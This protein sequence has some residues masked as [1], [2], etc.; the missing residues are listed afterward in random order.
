MTALVQVPD[1]NL[2]AVLASQ[3]QLRVDAVFYHVRRAP[4]GGNH[5]VMSQVPPEVVCQ[6]L[7]AT[8][9]FPGTLQLKRVRVH[10][11]N[12]TGAVSASRSECAPVNAVRSTMKRVGRRVA[13]LLYE[14]FGLDHLHNLRLPGIRLRVQNVNP[15]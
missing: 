11:E 13:S 12:A 2:V 9:L 3:Q 8:I 14:L 6:L 10:Q 1:M 7:W 4:F 15:G 5:R